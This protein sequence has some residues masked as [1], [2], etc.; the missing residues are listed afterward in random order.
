MKILKYKNCILA[1]TLV[2]AIL[3]SSF[4]FVVSANTDATAVGVWDGSTA[5]E[6]AGGTGTSADPFIIQSAAELRFMV[7]NYSTHDASNGKFFKIVNDIYLNDV[8]NGNSVVDLY[9][10]MLCLLTPLLH[11]LQRILFLL[12]L[13]RWWK[14]ITAP[15]V[16]DAV[17]LSVL[18]T[19]PPIKP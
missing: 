18:H 4:A 3:L 7:L 5:T 9:G 14:H 15:D 8:A 17:S 13:Q 1:Y 2:L 11:L 16:I 12:S 6:F 19:F 10:K